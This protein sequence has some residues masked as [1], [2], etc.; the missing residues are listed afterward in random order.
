MPLIE[1]IKSRYHYHETKDGNYT[2]NRE[3]IYNG[4]IPCKSFVGQMKI[5][6]SRREFECVCCSKAKA[7]GTRYVGDNWYRICLSCMNDWMN[8]SKKSFDKMKEA[9]T[10]QQNIL[11]KNKSNWEKEEIVANL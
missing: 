10:E 1:F 11:K 6:K 8:N 9:I 4:M 2:H 7:K 5:K 3:I